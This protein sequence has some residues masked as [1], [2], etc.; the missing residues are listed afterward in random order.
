MQC[1]K[2]KYAIRFLVNVTHISSCM[3]YSYYYPS[4][5]RMLWKILDEIIE[6]IFSSDVNVKYVY[7]LQFVELWNDNLIIFLF[8]NY[9][10]SENSKTYDYTDN[11]LI[12]ENKISLDV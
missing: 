2:K 9:I 1:G 10:I 3:H 12:V 8:D 6:M 11:P 5:S 7:I 4:N